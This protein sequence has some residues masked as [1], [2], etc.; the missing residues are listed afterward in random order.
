MTLPGL[1]KHLRPHNQ[2]FIRCA[3]GETKYLGASRERGI[4]ISMQE[5]VDPESF[6]QDIYAWMWEHLMSNHAGNHVPKNLGPEWV[7]GEIF[8]ILTEYDE[9]V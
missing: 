7:G 3:C 4:V 8:K 5:R 1:E 2:Y 6:L 9:R